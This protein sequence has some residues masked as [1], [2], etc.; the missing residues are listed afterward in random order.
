M[1]VIGTHLLFPSVEMEP[2]MELRLV[3]PALRIVVFAQL[4]PLVMA[5]EIGALLP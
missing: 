4:L 1:V 5:L 2:V 3:L